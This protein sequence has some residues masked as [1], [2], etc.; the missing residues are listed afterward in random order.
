MSRWY[1]CAEM[2]RIL[3]PLVLAFVLALSVGGCYGSYSAM[4]AVHRWN[5]HASTN[6]LVNSAI[7]LV[8]WVLPVYPLCIAGDFFI[9]NNV[10]FVTGSRVFN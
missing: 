7:H 8:F 3:A 1:T 6:R 2:K 9:F 5:G 4:H 10:E